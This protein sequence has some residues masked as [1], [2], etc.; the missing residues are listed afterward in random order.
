MK[1]SRHGSSTGAPLGNGVVGVVA[2][3]ALAVLRAAPGRCAI[4]LLTRG[5]EAIGR[6]GLATGAD[7]TTGAVAGGAMTIGAGADGARGDGAI[8]SEGARTTV[9]GASVTA[10]V[11]VVAGALD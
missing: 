5:A 2:T 9:A 11:T 1:A 10:G 8:A 6:D 3:G 7:A 4:T